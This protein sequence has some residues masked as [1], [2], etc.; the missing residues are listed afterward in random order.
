MRFYLP[1]TSRE[2]LDSA[3]PQRQAIIV[4]PDPEQ[5]DL[6]DFYEEAYS[7]ATF[8]ALALLLDRKEETV[9]P[10]R[11]ILCGTIGNGDPTWD[12]VESIMVDDNLN[13]ENILAVI[14][15]QTQEQMDE[16]VEIVLDEPLEW[17]DREEL[18]K[19]QQ[20]FGA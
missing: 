14:A 15:A 13:S 20:R 18:G 9:L 2:L 19:L 11:I 16:A 10:V 5:K 7:Q 3:L 6:D 8:D 4:A 1:I 12:D 17:F